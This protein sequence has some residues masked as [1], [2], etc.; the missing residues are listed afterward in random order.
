MA[1][2]RQRIILTRPPAT[3]RGLPAAG[4][5][6][7]VPV[8]AAAPAG[9]ALPRRE[10]TRALTRPV[11]TELADRTETTRTLG[12]PGETKR[13]VYH[14]GLPRRD[15]MSFVRCEDGPRLPTG[16]AVHATAAVPTAGVTG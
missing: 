2:N 10:R 6:A 15:L 3:R 14:A 9:R 13:C 5:A 4:A 7:P 16:D 8:G 11:T 12:R 1:D